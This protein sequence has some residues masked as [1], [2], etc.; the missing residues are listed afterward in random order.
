MGVEMIGGGGRAGTIGSRADLVMGI[1]TLAITWKVGNAPAQ[2][3]SP[4]GGYSH[5]NL[6]MSTLPPLSTHVQ[7]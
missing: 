7:S 4:Q 1:N 2:L 6:Y 5:V 3:R